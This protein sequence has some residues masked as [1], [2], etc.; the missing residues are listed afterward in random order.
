MSDLEAVERRQLERTHLFRG[1]A[2]ELIG[3][4]LQKC[5]IRELSQGHVLIKAGQ[6]NQTLYVLL[7]GRVSIHLELKL[8]PIAILGP[9]EICGELSL[10]DGEHTIAY[11]VA[12]ERCKV[13]EVTERILWPILTASPGVAR[14]FLTILARRLRHL[15]KQQLQREYAHYA[16]IDGLTGLYNRRWL[17]SMLVREIDRSK[18]GGQSL[19]LLLMCVDDFKSYRDIHGHQEGDCVLHCV[20]ST[21]RENL[22]PR[23]IIARYREDEFVVLLSETEIDSACRIGERLTQVISETQ[24]HSFDRTPLASVTASIGVAEM[25]TEDTLETF[26]CAAEAALSESKSAGGDQVSMLGRDS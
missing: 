6:R 17:D 5:P 4:L 3:D 14:N 13:L 9:G 8:K 15:S 7:S 24:V 10:I 23:E 11:V 25:T 26:V 16:V 2:P 19:C 20:A 12:E 18:R 22:R 21:L 1:V